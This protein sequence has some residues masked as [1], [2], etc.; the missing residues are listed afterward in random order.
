MSLR[1]RA[2]F[3]LRLSICRAAMSA[4]FAADFWLL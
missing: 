2:L 3:L 1:L 4:A